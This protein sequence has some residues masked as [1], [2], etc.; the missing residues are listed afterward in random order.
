[1]GN[2]T[3][4]SKKYLKARGVRLLDL[5]LPYRENTKLMLLPADHDID[6]TRSL[7]QS[8]ADGTNASVVAIQS[9]S[10]RRGK[11]L[12]RPEYEMV[13][14]AMPT[15]QASLIHSGYGTDGRLGDLPGTMEQ[16]WGML[17]I[18]VAIVYA[19]RQIAFI[20][21][22]CCTI[23]RNSRMLGS[24]DLGLH[25]RDNSPIARD[26]SKCIYRR[27][28]GGF[29]LSYRNQRWRV[30]VT[31]ISRDYAAIFIF[32]CLLSEQDCIFIGERYDLT[33][34]E[35]KMVAQFVKTPE[36]ADI[37]DKLHLSIPTARTVLRNIYDKMGV[38]SQQRLMQLLLTES[39]LYFSGQTGKKRMSKV[40]KKGR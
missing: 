9:N 25:L 17:S 20:N 4:A 3:N 10:P 12:A 34:A 5:S 19:G 18:G 6:D 39:S 15:V 26:V 31:P 40:F 13:H 33:A 29:D 21:E 16:L 8:I 30:T 11:A 38:N 37:A 22:T 7:S 32:C 24:D 27:Q 2:L 14:M 23:M 36:I 35:C 1:M 28:V